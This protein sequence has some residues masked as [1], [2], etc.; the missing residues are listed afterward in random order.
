MIS[1]VVQY[2]VMTTPTRPHQG[3]RPRSH[4]QPHLTGDLDIDLGPDPGPRPAQG[5]DYYRKVTNERE[6]G[7]AFRK[8]Q[9]DLAAR[10][11]LTE[12]WH[13]LDF[14]IK[15]LRLSWTRRQL[16]VA[17]YVEMVALVVVSAGLLL[18]QPIAVG[19]GA[20][21]VVAMTPWLV[22]DGWRRLHEWMLEES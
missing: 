6:M 12:D 2:R 3:H 14:S 18:S 19:V 4:R 22:R 20:L 11:E 5:T 8:H 10:Y 21:V 13:A 9:R 17:L 7:V 15:D 1:T 16:L